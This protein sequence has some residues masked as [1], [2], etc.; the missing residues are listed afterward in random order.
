MGKSVKSSHSEYKSKL[1]ELRT[2]DVAT[3]MLTWSAPR[4]ATSD[5]LCGKIDKIIFGPQAMIDSWSEENALI[6][7]T[8]TKYRVCDTKSQRSSK[9]EDSTFVQPAW[10]KMCSSADLEVESNFVE[11]FCFIDEV[12]RSVTDNNH[13]IL[14]DMPLVV[15]IAMCLFLHRGNVSVFDGVSLE[16]TLNSIRETLNK[17]WLTLEP[18]DGAFIAFLVENLLDKRK[19]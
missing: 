10:I 2:S 13:V 8:A 7:R 11:F 14:I 12:Y 17:S 6:Y 18:S 4:S 9:E 16:D 3:A 19:K 15:L 1:D 5:M